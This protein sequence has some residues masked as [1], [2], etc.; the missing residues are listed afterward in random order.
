MTP[1][2]V[3]AVGDIWY[4]IP[5]GIYF[6]IYQEVIEPTTFM[7]LRLDDGDIS[8]YVFT[9]WRLKDYWRLEA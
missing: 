3:P 5:T 7:I 9:S 4:N 2:P 6:L 8:E 1:T